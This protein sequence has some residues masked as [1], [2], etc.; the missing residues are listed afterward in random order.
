[1]SG[2]QVEL[3]RDGV[4]VPMKDLNWQ[5]PYTLVQNIEGAFTFWPEPIPAESTGIHKTFE[6]SVKIEAPEFETLVHGFRIPVI[7][8]VHPADF[9]SMERTF[10]LPD[11]YMFPP[12]GGED[13]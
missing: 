1:M 12:G 3:Y 2:I 13:D 4:L 8:E 10:K 9:F 5:N 6:Y 7:S 11:L